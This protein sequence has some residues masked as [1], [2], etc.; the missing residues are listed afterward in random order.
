[1]LFAL[2]ALPR[3]S[4]A[5][6]AYNGNPASL[7]PQNQVNAQ[8]ISDGAG[9]MIVA[10]ED[11][12]NDLASPTD[13]VD[14][15]AQRFD[16]SGNVM[17]GANGL[18]ICTEP[19]AQQSPVIC[20]DGQGGA[21]IAWQDLRNVSANY[22]IYVQSVAANGTVK[23]AADGVQLCGAANSQVLQ[24]IVPD[25]SKGAIV[26]WRDFRTTPRRTSRQT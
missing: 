25:G 8:A 17:W 1:M 2:L 5:S 19:A 3:P 24:V 7:A 23:W 9:G 12:R 11:Y 18:A 26:G 4:E 20:S 21:I 15:Y 13:S 22:D 6:W 14:I 16:A 10:W